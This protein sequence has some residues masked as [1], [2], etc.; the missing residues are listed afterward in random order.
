MRLTSPC[1]GVVLLV[2]ALACGGGGGGDTAGGGGAAKPAIT[3]FAAA[4]ASVA[5]GSGSTLTW[6]VTG[7]DHLRLDP[8]AVDVSGKTSR[9]VTPAATTTYTLTASNAAGSATATATVTV[10]L[11][12]PLIASFT[13]SPATIASGASATLAWSVSG[14][15]SLSLDQ[16]VGDVT[17]KT[18]IAVSPAATTAYTLTAT[19]A[20]GA[21][22]ASATVTVSSSGFITPGDPGAADITFTLSSQAT[23]AISPFIYGINGSQATDNTDWTWQPAYSG[24][25]RSGGNRW[26][27]YNWETNASN[28]GTDW[29]PYSSDNYLSASSAPGAAVTDRIDAARAGGNAALVTLQM[30][31]KVAADENGVVTSGEVATRFKDAVSAKGSAFTLTPDTTDGSVYMDEF[32]NLLKTKYLDGFTSGSAKPIFVELD[33]EP[34]LWNS[35][36]N[37]IQPTALRY[38]QLI[39]KSIQLSR[40]LKSVAPATK[41]FGPVSYGFSGY[42]NLQGAPDAPA[43]ITPDTY[44]WFLDDYLA[45][46]K[47]AS[48]G[49]G[50]RLLDALDLHWYPET[51][52]SGVRITDDQSATPP[53]A[54]VSARLQAPRALWDPA[55]GPAAAQD[56]NSDPNKDSSWIAVW[57]LGEPVRLIPRMKD[58]IAHG[59]PGT[60]LS[61]SEYEYGGGLHIS[62]ALAEAD[63]LGIFGREGLFSATYWAPGR[64]TGTGAYTTYEPYILA[65]FRMF[66]DY[67]DAGARFGDTGLSAATSD[68]ADSS[69][70]ASM[71][72]G[73]PDRVVIVAINKAA[74]AK[75]AAIR[76]TH[77]QV[78]HTA[79][80]WQ[81]VQQGPAI[82]VP[83]PARQADITLPVTNGLLYLMPPFSVTTL[84]LKP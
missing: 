51:Y 3:A 68:V 62:G 15:T 63:C 9:A 8:G 20:A 61:L 36:F 52:D 56:D 13:A 17:G 80:V 67:D 24:V 21:V 29:G 84:V 69:V 82:D 46:M 76:L 47:I 44:S 30:Q 16:G 12:K 25:V 58:K 45:Q 18:S 35:T 1:L 77:T 38:D 42:W 22:T 50:R 14:A 64:T 49:A 26:T 74:V 2:V 33:N 6:S 55:F 54:L 65:G 43:T 70:Y 39:P 32:L 19:N 81:L 60:E 4:P 59:F 11:P 83:K 5:P 53:A 75:S 27:A 10:A 72:A 41:V 78:L 40:A 48:D 28:A 34:D 73:V 57:V 31:G 66:L 37:L 71:D 7:A 79:E 23:H